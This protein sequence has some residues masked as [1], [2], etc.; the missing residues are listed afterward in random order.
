MIKV[1]LDV[2]MVM[3][4]TSFTGIPRVLM[5]IVKRLGT[6]EEF[7]F[8]FIE[9]D[10]KKDAYRVLKTLDFIEFCKTKND[11]R[12]HIRSNEYISI[13]E[14]GE[15]CIFFD[16]DTAWKTRVRRSFL[17]PILKQ[18]NV[19]IIT[20]IYDIISI[21][22]PQFCDQSDVMNFVDYFGATLLYAD[23]I[24]VT[25]QDTK[26]AIFYH[27]LKTN[28]DLPEIDIIPLGG[29]FKKKENAEKNVK[30]EVKD[31]VSKGKYLLMVGTIEPRKNHKLLLKAYKSYLRYKIN[32][33]F[34]GF[35]GQG[36]DDF[37]ADLTSDPDYNNGIWHVKNASDDDIDYLYKNAFAMVFPSYIEGYGLPIIESFVREV[38]V[39]AADTNI[40]REIAGERAIFFEQ[41]NSI[42]LSDVVSDLLENEQKYNELC[43]RV[44]GYVPKT[45]DDTAA[46]IKKSLKGV[47]K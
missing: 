8:H 24:I 21:D 4:G 47:V 13:E 6:D 10:S 36:M 28:V 23:K 7:N 22:Y 40:N 37:F 46:G 20:L 30:K 41:D 32:F 45:W 33:V 31:I 17:Y 2:S 29:D 44:K 38:P 14:I 16:C 3:I 39:I 15:D 12:N 25:S 43:E 1:Y 35:S 19:K 42:E 9:Y 27:C 11:N 5:E 34:A 18:N 26:D